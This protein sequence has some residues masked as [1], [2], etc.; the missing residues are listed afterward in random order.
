MMMRRGVGRIVGWR[1]GLGSKGFQI[2]LCTS[3]LRE[4]KYI[5]LRLYPIE[6]GLSDFKGNIKAYVFIREYALLYF[7]PFFPDDK[8][9]MMEAAN[10]EHLPI[11]KE[12]RA[13]LEYYPA[14]LKAPWWMYTGSGFLSLF[15]AAVVA[16]VVYAI[17][18]S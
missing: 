2:K 14:K 17:G 16:V 9:W 5:Q 8:R 18:Y 6:C 4:K 12:M 11:Q 10:G 7:I 15:F 3:T 1:L 13:N